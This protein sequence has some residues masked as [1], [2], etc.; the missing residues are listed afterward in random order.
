LYYTSTT[1]N[2]YDNKIKLLNF[3][4]DTIVVVEFTIIRGFTNDPSKL[5]LKQKV[6][7]IDIS[8]IKQQKYLK[9]LEGDTSLY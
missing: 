6:T 2:F 7:I 4:T 9:F 1:C 5:F 8:I 3:L